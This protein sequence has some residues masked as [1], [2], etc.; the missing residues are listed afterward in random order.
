M[1]IMTQRKVLVLNKGCFPIGV[2]T[3]ERAMCVVTSHYKDKTPK[4]EILDVEDFRYFTWADWA[5]LIP[6]DG[7][8]VIRSAK[9][10]FRIPEIIKLTRY[11]KLP[12]QKVHFSRRTIYRRD[13]NQ[14]QY[15][16]EKPGTSELSIDHILPRSRGG[17]TS[18]T[19]CVLACTTCNR[20][21]AD[22]TPEEANM[23]LL[24]KPRKP[25]YSFYK[26]DYR[27]KSWEAI[28]GVAYWETEL[29][30]DM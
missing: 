17:K 3:L 28:L 8:P 21:K 29:E 18:W 26:G 24:S 13:A 6:R 27:C 5:E 20:V 10:S 11:N 12:Q 30:N 1:N 23:K 7:E 25:K 15:C 19:N 22:K 16:G 4:A 14:C 2:I 9:S